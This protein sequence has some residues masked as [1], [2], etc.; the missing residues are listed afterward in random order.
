[1]KGL[2]TVTVAEYGSC[3][4]PHLNFKF[5]HQGNILKMHALLIS[6]SSL[7][8]SPIWIPLFSNEGR[9]A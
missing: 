2:S 4:I 6:Q 1:V 9:S 7:D 3:P 5:Y 8:I